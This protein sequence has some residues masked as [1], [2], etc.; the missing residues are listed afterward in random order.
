MGFMLIAESIWYNRITLCFP[1]NVIYNYF[2]S[3]YWCPDKSAHQARIFKVL[4]KFVL[5]IQPLTHT[6]FAVNLTDDLEKT[7]NKEKL[8]AKKLINYAESTRQCEKAKISVSEHFTSSAFLKTSL[9]LWEV[10]FLTFLFMCPNDDHCHLPKPTALWIY[11]IVCLWDLAHQ[12]IEN[13]L[14]YKVGI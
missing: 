10:L 11:L 14:T 3:F 12:H 4:S 5:R 7:F 2:Y 8:E 13:D 9:G 1:L 6:I